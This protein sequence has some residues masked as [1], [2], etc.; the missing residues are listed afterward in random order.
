MMP[1]KT[2]ASGKECPVVQYFPRSTLYYA[3]RGNV[4]SLYLEHCRGLQLGSSGLVIAS[5]QGSVD[6]EAMAE[7]EDMDESQAFYHGGPQSGLQ[8]AH[9]ARSRRKAWERGPHSAVDPQAHIVTFSCNF[10]DE[11]TKSGKELCAHIRRVHRKHLCMKCWKMFNSFQALGYHRNA[12]HGENEGL[13]CHICHKSF[14]HLQ[15][16]NKHIRNV[17]GVERSCRLCWSHFESSS[18]LLHHIA[19]VHSKVGCPHCGEIFNS[20]QSLC[21]HQ[22]KR[23]RRREELRCN[24]C[25][26]MFTRMWTKKKHM[27]SVHQ[28]FGLPKI[29]TV[30][31]EERL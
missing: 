4:P 30:I 11:V 24:V 20:R 16:K 19:K 2:C 5:V 15:H 17:H 25:G 12:K 23:H 1:S 28:I 22:D 10:C 18:Q 21:Y 6:I 26:K 29:V 27:E 3:L 7:E 31:E 13:I 14:A 8:T 9:F